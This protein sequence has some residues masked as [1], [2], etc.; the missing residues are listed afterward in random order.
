M[1]PGR[2]L[3]SGLKLLKRCTEIDLS[4]FYPVLIGLQHQILDLLKEAVCN[5]QNS[6]YLGRNYTISLTMYLLQMSFVSFIPMTFLQTWLK[7]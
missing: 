6:H 5:E 1:M 7:D 2:R 3:P 4:A